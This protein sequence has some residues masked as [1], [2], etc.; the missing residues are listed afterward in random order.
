MMQSFHG[1]ALFFVRT[2]QGFCAIILANIKCKVTCEFMV[3]RII[4]SSYDSHFWKFSILKFLL[5]HCAIFSDL[6]WNF[7]SLVGDC[8]KRWNIA[9]PYSRFNYGIFDIHLISIYYKFIESFLLLFF[10][11]IWVIILI[12]WHRNS[13]FI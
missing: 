2:I 4:E 1:L 9:M 12:H 5:F 13:K 10:S 6:L 8:L 3:D 7:S 11:W